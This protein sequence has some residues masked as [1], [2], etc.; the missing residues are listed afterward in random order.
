[1]NPILMRLF[2]F[3]SNT[4]TW[5]LLKVLGLSILPRNVSLGG[6]ES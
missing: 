5:T 3:L 4:G 1:M 2:L 6:F